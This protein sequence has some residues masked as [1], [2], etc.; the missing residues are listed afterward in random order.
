MGMLLTWISFTIHRSKFIIAEIRKTKRMRWWESQPE[1]GN[2]GIFFMVI[3]Y[4]LLG[5]FCFIFI[6]MVCALRTPSV[7]LCFVLFIDCNFSVFVLLCVQ[8][9]NVNSQ[10]DEVYARDK[11]TDNNFNTEWKWFNENVN[12]PLAWNIAFATTI[13]I[14]ATTTTT[15]N[16]T[17]CNCQSMFEAKSNNKTKNNRRGYHPL[18]ER[19]VGRKLH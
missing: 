7:M 18:C 2:C 19:V 11:F 16:Q 1:N 8:C 12:R 10:S 15:F 14:D 17:N 3:R 5:H 13:I 4:G 6:D 9:N